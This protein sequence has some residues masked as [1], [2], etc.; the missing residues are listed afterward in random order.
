M[1]L[2]SPLRFLWD[3]TTFGG[4]TDFFT[5]I[6]KQLIGI[7]FTL[8]SLRFATLGL[9]VSTTEIYAWSGVGAIAAMIFL[10]YLT[11]D[12]G[13]YTI[14]QRFHSWRGT[15]KSVFAHLFIS[16]FAVIIGYAVF[17][18]VIQQFQFLA[19]QPFEGAIG[20]AVVIIAAAALATVNRRDLKDS[21]QSLSEIR[22]SFEEET[23]AS[24][25]NIENEITGIG[26]IER[27]ETGRI[28][29]AIQESEH[30]KLLGDGGVGK[31]GILKK[32]AEDWDHELLFIDATR[33]P[34]VQNQAQLGNGLR[35]NDPIKRALQQVALEAPLAV[36][37]DQLDDIGGTERQTF[38]D[39]LLTATNLQ[40][41]R[42][43]F[44]C[45]EHD[46][47]TRSEYEPLRDPG[48]FSTEAHVQ[49]LKKPT[50][51]DYI[52]QLTGAAP[53]EELVEVGRNIQYLDVIAELA[54]D[55]T[56]LSDISGEAALWDRY[57]ERLSEEFQPGDD[58]RRGG[59]VVDRA[60]HYAIDATEAGANVFSLPTDTDWADRQLLNTG[61]IVGARDEPGERRHRFRHPDFQT[62]LYAWEAV[63]TGKSIQEVTQ[64]LDDR[65]GKD[66]FRWMLALYVRSE[67]SL[68]DQLPDPA[69]S[70]EQA[71]NTREFLKELL[72]EEA[73]LG[74]YATTV[75]L[76]EIKTWDAAT[77][78]E[79][80]DIVLDKLE[81][82]DA[83]YSYLLDEN[84]DPSWAYKLQ[85]RGA[86]NEPSE[87]LIGF[88]R[89]LG[90]EYPEA[91]GDILNDI[92][93]TDPRT[94]AFLI[95]ALRELPAT[96][97]ANH[98]ELVHSFLSQIDQPNDQRSFEAVQLTQELLT[99]GHIDAGLQLLD[100][101]LQPRLLNDNQSQ[102]QSI[103]D[104]HFLSSTLDDTLSTILAEA[105]EDCIE[106]L[107]T[108]LRTAIQLEA[109][110][111]DRD[112]E[113]IVGYYQAP[114]ST[115]EFD[116]PGYTHLRGLLTGAL[117][118]AIEHWLDDASAA[119]RQ[120]FIESYLDDIALFR[121]LGFHL[122]NRYHDSCPTLLRQE[123]LNETNYTEPWTETDF[124]DLLSESFETLPHEDQEQITEIILS[125][126]VEDQLAERAEQR[127]QQTDEITADELRE[128]YIDD[129][130]RERLQL[131]QE[132]LP[133]KAAERYKTLQEKYDDEPRD[134]VSDSS[135]QAGFVSQES[136][137]P[138]DKLAAMPPDEFL[139]F[140]INWKPDEEDQGWE[141]T[142][143]GGFREVNQRGLAE[144][145][146]EVILMEPSRYHTQ[147]PQ[148]RQA[149]SI[150]AEKLFESIRE[151]LEDTPDTFTEDFTWSPIFDLC[152]A[153]A[154]NPDEWDSS[155]RISTARLLKAA[156][157]A[158]AYHHMIEYA[159]QIKPLFFHLLDDPDPSPSRDRP[160]EGHA[161]HQNPLHVALNAVR[162]IAVDGLIIYALRRAEHHE[163]QGY[164]EEDESGFE[165]DVR[166]QLLSMIEDEALSVRSIF[167]R[168]L[169]HLWYLDH[170]LV[171]DNLETLFPR[172]QSTKA[173][174][175]FSAAWDAYVG[176]NILH[177]DLFPELRQCY[178]HGIDLL[179]E[180]ENTAIINAE[181]GLA[182]HVISAYLFDFE[183]LEGEDSMVMYLYDRDDPELARQVA[184]RLWRS[185][186]DEEEIRQKWEK[187]RQLWQLRLDQVDDVDA[188][189][190][191]IQW[192]IEWLPLADDQIELDAVE[193]LI[194]DSLPFIVH[195]RRSWQTLEEYLSDH[196][197]HATETVITIYDELMEHKPRPRRARFSEETAALLKPGVDSSTPRIRRTAL[198]IAEQFAEDGDDD[199]RAFLN[200]E[201]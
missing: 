50:A 158:E 126:P 29:N 57:R 162:P 81:S 72:D 15:A 46:L 36:I 112:P 180:D 196:A 69:E 193:P 18:T 150:Y 177:E 137:K 174:N 153:I 143:S 106:L 22:E 147:I 44:A 195:T 186:K 67:T 95:S 88:L 49:R 75:I 199:A 8:A 47:K 26:H 66:V 33:H 76:D 41:V 16:L 197:E 54:N 198:D 185:G 11:H 200:Q 42:V 17:S 4:E 109:D 71:G 56:D 151:E 83:L 154:E 155:A 105:P 65:L 43:V 152:E 160:P 96:E 120:D 141:V 149:D 45:R 188:Y 20:T 167:G 187:V 130:V 85:E 125:V 60:V 191:E 194:R 86:F 10:G 171:L 6:L 68:S 103:A 156:F 99:R 59:R 92:T 39:F 48:N 115:A 142:E 163:Y 135:V 37:A 134:L 13:R 3:Y 32:V 161:G 25:E 129:W 166:S 100:V 35:L 140:L 80:A 114:I 84:T 169:H 52:E 7:V 173:K 124:L 34:D 179:T 117:R 116:E 159:D 31:S 58:D 175:L 127:S 148:L 87:R 14:E 23:T 182:N 30:A 110:L 70:P 102:P 168:R 178:F 73:G 74:Y 51:Q 63:E 55:G 183:A 131:I 108:H 93:V 64:E 79:L 101:L 107:E 38:C 53:T 139:Q 181:E 113:T 122:L 27:S 90:P 21:F 9:T 144:A 170:P 91:V 97:A 138:V 157:T 172:K 119:T 89:D 104:L 5:N 82:R 164:S 94:Q 1:N 77:H 123:L 190:D 12:A 145:A 24:L 111:R 98:V 78:S 62:Y 176:S 61:V 165:P 192:F 132:H 121:R 40:N 201:T 128:R 146:S 189:A 136:P 118:E 184:W 19:I 133:A 28:L 2:P